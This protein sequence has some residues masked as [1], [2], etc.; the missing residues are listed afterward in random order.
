MEM[1]ISMDELDNTENLENGRPN[2]FLFR[3][4]LTDSKEFTSF[5]PTTPQYKKLKN[6]KFTSITWRMTDQNDKS[7][8]EGPGTTVVLHIR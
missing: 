5:K 1:V 8:A 2:N 4:Y 3:N 7:M 6:G